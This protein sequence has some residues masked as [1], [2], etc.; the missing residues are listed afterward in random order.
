MLCIH[1]VEDK[2]SEGRGRG[3]KGIRVGK[4]EKKEDWRRK[5]RET[6]KHSST[7]WEVKE[8]LLT[9]DAAKLCA[10]VI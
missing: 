2:E 3:G 5:R 4:E 7:K 8:V 9:Y 10:L 1:R 6:T